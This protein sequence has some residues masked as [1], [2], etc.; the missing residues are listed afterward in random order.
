MNAETHGRVHLREQPGPRVE[1]LGGKVERADEVLTPLALQ[2]LGSLH[3][4]FNGR[5]LELLEARTR[6][7]AEFDAG[8]LPEFPAATAALR[9]AEWRVAPVPAD[10]SNRRVEITGPVDRKMIINALNAPVQA[11]M[12]DFEDANAPTWANCV[13]GQA[14]LMDAV[15]RTIT[16]VA[17]ETGKHYSLGSQ[18]ATLLV[19][20]RGFHLLEKHCLV[21]ERP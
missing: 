14:N 12:A 4:R 8:A 2:L 15:R 6:R 10:L 16:Y 20:P 5:R 1:I 17:P 7:Q 9:A 13:G 11:F 21:D 18:V 3:R 19:R